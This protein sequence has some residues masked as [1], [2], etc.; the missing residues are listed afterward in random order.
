MQTTRQSAPALTPPALTMKLLRLHGV[1]E[2]TALKKSAIYAAM[3]NKDDPFPAP[4]RIGARA[5]AWHESEVTAWIESR[6]KTKSEGVE[7]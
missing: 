7:K 1:E 5:V 2:R 3:A 6:A 4:V